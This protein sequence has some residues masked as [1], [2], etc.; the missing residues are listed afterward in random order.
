MKFKTRLKLLAQRAHSRIH[1]YSDSVILDFNSSVA[2]SLFEGVNFVGCG[3]VVSDSSFGYGSYVASNSQ[4]VTSK[5]GRF[6]SIG[7]NVLMPTGSHP[8]TTFVSTSPVFYSADGIMGMSFTKKQKWQDLTYAENGYS[9][10]IG[11]DVW[12][13]GGASI[14]EG[15]R[16]GDGAIVAAGAV[17]T[18]DVPSYAVVGGG[19]SSV[20]SI[21]F[22]TPTN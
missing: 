14:L 3:S 1:G 16:I 4:V 8:S 6:T 13:C 21:P 17:V 7:P 20:D 15:V 18:K 9:R 12:I 2:N 5:I 22:F 11:N 10:L 19:S